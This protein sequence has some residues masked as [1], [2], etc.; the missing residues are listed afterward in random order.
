MLQLIKIFLQKKY[1]DKYGI[2][3]DEAPLSREVK[4]ILDVLPKMYETYTDK[5]EFSVSDLYLYFIGHTTIKD[6]EVQTYETIFH[7]LGTITIDEQLIEDSLRSLKVKQT[8]GRLA[9][10]AFDVANGTKSVEDI[11]PYFEKLSNLRGQLGEVDGDRDRFVTDDLETLYTQ[12]VSTPGLRW[13]SKTLSKMLGSLRKGDFGFIFARPETG[14]TTFLASEITYFSSQTD[15][16]ILWFSNEEQGNKVM[17]RV[18]QASLGMTLHELMADR[19]GNRVKYKDKTGGNIRIYDS[20]SIHRREVE[21]LCKSVGPG[22]I[23]FDQIDK[24]KG[25]AAD[26]DDLQLGEIYI[27]AR[28][29]AK[30]YCP[31]IG[32]CQAGVTGEGKRYLTMDDVVNAKTSKQAEADWI[33]GIGKSHDVDEEYTRFFCLSKNKLSGDNDTD[34][35][36]RHGRLPV[37]INPQIARYEDIL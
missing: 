26:R 11:S 20:A 35:S 21:V 19:E 1:W 27:W 2:V 17:V 37:R 28:E 10:D 13:R 18:Y 3:W 30:Q 8:A 12:T 34:E 16:P 36:L 24:I 7:E 4:S 31:V 23:V 6:K 9:L 22:L 33:L 32:V 15:R 5:S 25:F 29:L 14:K